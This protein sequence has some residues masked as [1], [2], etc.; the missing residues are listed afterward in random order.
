MLAGRYEILSPLGKGGMGMV[1]KARDLALDDIVAV[2]V[3]RAEI[4]AD[5]DSARRFRSEIKLARRVT[6]RNVNRIHEFGVDG[7]LHFISMEFVDG[8]DLK[9]ILREQGSLPSLAAIDVA[10]Q[11]CDG[12]Q[13]IHDVGIV[14]RDLKTTN[15]M[16]DAI[17]LIRLMDFGIAK[18]TGAGTEQ[19]SGATHTGQIVGTPEYMSPEQAR[20]ERLDQTS[21]IYSFGIVL[22]E[23]LTGQVPFRGDTP[24]ATILKHINDAPPLHGR[25]VTGVSERVLGII[26]RALAKNPADRFES[27]GEMGAALREARPEAASAPVLEPVKG[28]VVP[29]PAPQEYWTPRPLRT[30]VPVLP[31]TSP[32]L[33]TGELPPAAATFVT[34]VSATSLA[35]G[36]APHGRRAGVQT[37]APGARSAPIRTKAAGRGLSRTAAAVVALLGGGGLVALVAVRLG[38]PSLGSTREQSAL[39]SPEPFVTPAAPSTP[40]A[41]LEDAQSPL[42]ADS[43]MP[44]SRG[45]V[46]STP[47]TVPNERGRG[48]IPPTERPPPRPHAREGEAQQPV[49]TVSP[50]GVAP[51]AAREASG[52]GRTA[53]V[54]SPLLPPAEG[55]GSPE[56]TAEVPKAASAEVQSQDSQS[57]QAA[58]ATL[59]TLRL[60]VTPWA[61][62]MVDGVR[63]GVSPPL[64]P[65]SLPA[66][67][68]LVR[69]MHPDYAPFSRRVSIR[70]GESTLLDVDLT[71]EAFPK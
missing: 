68:H 30:E 40:V 47:G 29:Q 9:R 20:G 65:I 34:P 71:K 70:S 54:P 13:A 27:V 63:V 21:D 49:S 62:V 48:R 31:A 19:L 43:P 8:V 53:I 66:G 69:L 22:F 15:I 55:P 4:A 37:P 60:A 64:K 36:G 61:E 50:R 16:R 51:S 41:Q 10:V 58:A 28:A 32:S 2:K 18:Q 6:H 1:Y 7:E 3:L 35:S 57:R 24:I 67:V 11:I 26:R 39:K 42:A 45:V 38:G 33:E 59:G 23:L 17:G 5:P 14:H 12:L 44:E 56:K 52:T 25:A 46:G